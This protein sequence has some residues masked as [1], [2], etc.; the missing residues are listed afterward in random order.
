MPSFIQKV[1]S[2]FSTSTPRPPTAVSTTSRSAPKPSRQSR[3]STPPKAS[4]APK[5]SRQSRHSTP[6]KASKAPTAVRERRLSVISRENCKKNNLKNESQKLLESIIF[7]SSLMFEIEEK[8]KLKFRKQYTYNRIEKIK[9]WDKSGKGDKKFTLTRVKDLGSGS[10]G[11][12][13]LLKGKSESGD[14][15]K[16][17]IKTMIMNDE[18][19]IGIDLMKS[20]CEILRVK[21]F[22]ADDTVRSSKAANFNAFMEPAHDSLYNY[23]KTKTLTTEQIL[24]IGQ[25]ILEQLRCLHKLTPTEP[26][27]KKYLYTDLKPSNVLYFDCGEEENEKRLKVQLGDLGSAVPTPG[28]NNSNDFISTY[29]AFE[30]RDRGGHYSIDLD[31][32]NVCSQVTSYQLGMLLFL[33]MEDTSDKA[34]LFN[35]DTPEEGSEQV[36][37]LYSK[38]ELLLPGLKNLVHYTPGKRPYMFTDDSLKTLIKT[39]DPEED[40]Y[41]SSKK[42]GSVKKKQQKGKKGKKG[43]PSQKKKKK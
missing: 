39:H 21:V 3:H 35:K 10:Y 34:F 37:E 32:E 14:E 4:K 29:P 40:F 9:I 18:K 43:R 13:Y 6:P 5:P 22:S 7:S 33:L 15:I 38:L 26:L 8:T 2:L 1:V 16:I 17:T 25:Q 24:D 30:N 12:V 42:R 11:I 31:D 20:D 19:Y 27:V 28:T 41:S 23:I 36:K